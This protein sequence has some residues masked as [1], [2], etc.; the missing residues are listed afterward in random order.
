MAEHI[1]HLTA[2]NHI[3]NGAMLNVEKRH[4]TENFPLH[5]HSFFEFELILDG[6]G[7]QNF[8]GDHVPLT[9]GTAHILRP[10]DFH[11]QHV[12]SELT[13]YNIMFH[14]NILSDDFIESLLNIPGNILA[15]LEGEDLRNI[16]FLISILDRECDSNS[17]FKDKCVKNLFE[18]ILMMFMRHIHPLPH[19]VSV[20]AMPMRKAILY[21]HMHF[22]EN[23]SL[24]TTAKLTA[25]SENYFSEQFHKQTGLT[26]T[27][28]LT[29]L[30]LAY[31]RRL[32]EQSRLTST[33][34]CFECGFSSLSN[35][36]K[37]F[38]KHMG[39]SPQEYRANYIGMS[40]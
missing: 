13:V 26:Y 36:L 3:R 1:L 5:W 25:F 14:E 34:I 10:T 8:N 12:V 22:R 32:L 40:K 21:M 33:D 9:E 6:E 7:Y 28:Y 38:K 16:S 23:P 31:A 30:K 18:T 24:K 15:K 37:I 29:R 11:D 2:D 17:E 27:E 39:L 4:I 20:S 19:N 35:F